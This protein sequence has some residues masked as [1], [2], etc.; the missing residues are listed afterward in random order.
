MKRLALASLLF[1]GFLAPAGFPPAF[2]QNA[3]D[4]S[5]AKQVFENTCAGCHG[6][7]GGGGERAPS[8]SDNPDL[9]KLDAP[10]IESIIRQGTPGGMPSFASLPTGQITQ[11]A[12]W[13][14]SMNLSALASA[15]PEQVSAGE[16]FFSGEGR[17]SSCHMVRGVGSVNGPDLSNIAARSSM[18][19]IEKV[20]DDP[21]SQLG[22]HSL[23]VCP[24]WSF[25][26]DF[27]WAVVDVTLKNGTQLRGFG[28]KRTEHE[29]Q[30]QT[31]DGKL[32]LLDAGDY[33]NFRQER[34]AYMPPLKAT[35]DQRRD[36]LAYLSTLGGIEAGPVAGSPAPATQAA[37]DAVVHPKKG[38]WPTY[39]GSVDGNRYSPLDQ[40]NTANVRQLQPQFLFAP[41]GNGLESTP[42]V[43][44]GV[45]YV[46]G[47]PQTCAL[48]ARTGSTIWC[49]PRTNGLGA[50]VP[51]GR[52][53][54]GRGG[55]R[56]AA[57]A[58]PRGPN[59]GVAVLGNR[60]FYVSDDDYMV[61][62]NSLTG[63]VMWS[64]PLPETGAIGRY[65]NSSAPLVVGNLVVSGV[66][67][68]DGPIR[69]FLVAFDAVTGKLA[70][71][72][73]T[74]PKPGE[75]PSESWI[76]R[77]LPTGGGATWSTGSYDAETDTLFWAIGNPYP[78]T[79]PD[80]R[81][82]KNLYTNCVVA[83]DPKT[84]KL[85]WYFQFTPRDTHDWDAT[86][87][88][89]LVDSTWHGKPRKL[90]L[91]A[92]RSG[93]FYV[94]DRTNGQFLLAKPFVKK[95]T[96]ASG[97]NADG[98]PIM[99]PGQTPTVEGTKTC[100]GVRG[101]TNWYSTAFDP[102]TKLFYVMAAEDCGVYRKTGRIWDNNPDPNDIGTRY[103]RALNIETGDVAWEK[104]LVGPQETDY[105]GV[106]ATAGGLVF[107]GEIGGDFAAVDAKTGKTLWTFRS[108][109]S[110]RASPMTYMVDGRQYVAG[111]DGSNVI[112]F[113][114]GYK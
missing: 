53:G 12:Q 44:D 62:L 75:P 91:S 70:W 38:D 101:A 113:A 16:K 95:M 40:I 25:C 13:L 9:R 59:R 103:V 48:D 86:E 56:P 32:H 20:L 39:N 94:L 72:F 8:L 26:P 50:G 14:H 74:I 77:A 49:T 90:L 30:L 71:R 96:W 67:G 47:I 51:Q 64:Q 106:L 108:N 73:Y 22:T 66:A 60:V 52:G 21:T 82:G 87:P 4:Y 112:S 107:H 18:P 104:L 24:S 78:D 92:Q 79:D 1:A 15:P 28:R 68:G 63:A 37:I 54:G 102:G 23:S 31:F 110:W 19:E 98:S 85:K 88:M 114:L 42:V 76:G 69:G 43:V 29:L 41:G 111:T 84:G 100:P 10:G 35:A 11:L 5:A 27:S 34:Q 3:P 2:A 45:M 109:D 81:E 58:G 65:Y 105:T 61:C 33:T 6:S 46:T 99:I 7:G 57:A 83:L 17:C 89:L 80:Q 36:L 55:A 97:F 93:I